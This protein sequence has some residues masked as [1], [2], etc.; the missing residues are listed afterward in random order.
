M[1][2]TSSPDAKGIRRRTIFSLSLLGGLALLAGFIPKAKK[3][4]RRRFGPIGNTPHEPEAWSVTISYRGRTRDID[5]MYAGS[6]IIAH[7]AG[8][9]PAELELA[10]DRAARD[11]GANIVEPL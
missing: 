2:T 11:A 9:V 4:C 8:A 1:I 6:A 10:I 3:I 5:G 7:G